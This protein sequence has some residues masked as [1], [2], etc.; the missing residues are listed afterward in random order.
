MKNKVVSTLFGL[1]AAVTFAQQHTDTPQKP[2]SRFT[3]TSLFNPLYSMEL[4][5]LRGTKVFDSL[6][7]L[8]KRRERTLQNYDSPHFNP[9]LLNTFDYSKNYS[10]FDLVYAFEKVNTALKRKYSQSSLYKQ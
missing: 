5:N 1:M 4:Q 9:K 6:V 7:D 10:G 2:I 8:C 3:N